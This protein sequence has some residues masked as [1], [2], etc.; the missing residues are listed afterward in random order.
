MLELSRTPNRGFVIEFFRLGLPLESGHGLHRML[1]VSKKQLKTMS[2]AE[3]DTIVAE[4]A[5]AAARLPLFSSDGGAID[6]TSPG[7]HSV[8]GLGGGGAFAH[9]TAAAAGG[10]GG[11][12]AS[13]EDVEDEEATAPYRDIYGWSELDWLTYLNTKKAGEHGIIID[14]P[15]PAA[16]ATPVKAAAGLLSSSSATVRAAAAAAAAQPPPLPDL[17]H[18]PKSIE[19]FCSHPAALLAGLDRAQVLA[20]R[21]YSSGAFPSVSEQLRAKALAHLMTFRPSS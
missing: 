2:L 13:H 21:I 17:A 14:K 6:A 3:S 1:G 16:V 18:E 20:L 8:A 9:S 10:G 4:A 12:R 11:R 7:A 19:G 5:A 15:T